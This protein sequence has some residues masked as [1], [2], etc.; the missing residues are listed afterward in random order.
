L[1]Y[2]EYEAEAAVYNGVLLGPSTTLGQI[3]SEASG[4]EA[5]DL[6]GTG[7]YVT[8]TTLHPCN[9]IV[10]RYSIPDAPGGGG[11]NATLS[12]FVN[13]AFNQEL[14][15][16]SRYSWDYKNWSYPYDKNPADGSPFHFF[17]EA[18]A[19]LG[20]EVPAGSTV[21][22]QKQASD[23]ASWYVVDLIDLEEVAAPAAMPS[24][25]TPITNYGAVGDGS[26]DNSAAIQACVNANS[27]V[28]I[29]QGNFACLSA[30][31]NVPAGVTVQGAGMW[32]SVLSGYYATLNLGGGNDR[33][34]N[35]AL[36]GDTVNRVD[37]NPDNGFNNLAGTGSLL[38]NI[39]IE[40]EKCGYWVGNSSNP[41]TNGLL[42]TGCRIRDTYADG[43][44]FC[45]GT[46]D[47]TVT[48]SQFRNT[49]DDS[50]A[51]W[52]P[53]GGP[54]NSGNLFSFNTVQNTWRADC[55]ALYGG[56]SNAIE[57]NLCSDTLDQSGILV[58]QGFTSNPFSGTSSILRN[59][60]TRA[61]GLF[62][63]AE[64]GALQFWGNQAALAGAFTIDSLL[65]V[66]P[67]YQGVVFNGSY[68][69]GGETFTNT[70]INGAG[71]WAMMVAS[72]T[73]GTA[74]FS[75]TVVTAPGT[76][77]MD[78]LSSNFTV[79]KGSGDSGW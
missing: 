28:W 74:T 7:N 16:T 75:S 62:N 30:A 13:G 70:Q 79:V 73:R 22:L 56:S 38:Q 63:G 54:V 17:D 69:S 32:H 27:Q 10:V 61:G 1:P 40:H 50:L 68:A 48:Q 45:N 4:R 49:G 36:S 53:S 14:P 35:F 12:V 58:E 72:T 65:I 20:M 11:I 57:D 37:S 23:T 2:D 78:N 66:N 9:S 24:G 71:T 55:F 64:Y 76:G 42:I 41:V 3:A 44:N 18:H 26:T 6:T 60:L 52:S 21:T 25:Y 77:G 31:I 29:P 59:T 15:L 34:L 39:W 5:V 19:L 8:F 46:S 51:S 67:T 33:F 47:S 43:V